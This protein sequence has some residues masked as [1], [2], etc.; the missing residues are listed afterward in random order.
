[1][2]RKQGL[3]FQ[4]YRWFE[5]LV[6]LKTRPRFGTGSQAWAKLVPSVFSTFPLCSK[7]SF[8]PGCHEEVR[9]LFHTTPTP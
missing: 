6:I 9:P 5:A 3:V 4:L 8:S 7:F 1:M 2:E